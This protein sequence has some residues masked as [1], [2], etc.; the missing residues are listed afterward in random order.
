MQS[1]NLDP[2]AG[3][4]ARSKRLGPDDPTAGE[5]A[6][7]ERLR[8]GIDHP[9]TDPTDSRY[10]GIAVRPTRPQAGREARPRAGGPARIV[11]PTDPECGLPGD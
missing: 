5:R 6:R 4:P 1:P 2:T 7:R 3:E 9:V 8:P 10:A 11:D